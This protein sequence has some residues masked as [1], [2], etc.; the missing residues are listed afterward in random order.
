MEVVYTVCANEDEAKAISKTL[1]E[2]KLCACV[3]IITN[4]QSMY[5][6]EGEIVEDNEV[7]LLIKTIPQNF[8]RVKEVIELEHSYDVPAIFALPVQKVSDKYLNWMN[9]V[10]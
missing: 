6:W 5:V 9:Q 1:L 3:N 8:I 2:Q 7:V 10:M 4:M